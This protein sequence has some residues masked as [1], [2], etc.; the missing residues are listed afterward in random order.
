M[1]E[2]IGRIFVIYCSLVYSYTEIK[3]EKETHVTLGGPFIYGNVAKSRPIH[4]LCFCLAVNIIWLK[5]SRAITTVRWGFF[6]SP[7]HIKGHC[8]DLHSFIDEEIRTSGA[9]LRIISGTCITTVL[10]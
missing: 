1:Q 3:G 4:E 6:V 10:P 9:H 2:K 5:Y 8:K 7:C